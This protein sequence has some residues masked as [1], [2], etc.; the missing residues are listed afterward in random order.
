MQ[1]HQK[2][3]IHPEQTRATPSQA[4]DT[5]ET[6]RRP[7]CGP[8]PVRWPSSSSSSSPSSLSLRARLANWPL[9][10]LVMV[11]EEEEEEVAVVLVVEDCGDPRR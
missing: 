2:E 4:L 6:L 1:S 9:A 5:G 7:P 3:V 8:S 11:V 10:P